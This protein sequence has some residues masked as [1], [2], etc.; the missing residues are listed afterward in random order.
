MEPGAWTVRIIVNRSASKNFY[1]SISIKPP[2]KHNIIYSSMIGF[3]QHHEI[4]NTTVMISLPA[5]AASAWTSIRASRVE[6]L[7]RIPSVWHFRVRAALCA[8][9]FAFVPALWRIEISHGNYHVCSRRTNSPYGWIT[10]CSQLFKLL[11]VLR[12]K[13]LLFLRVAFLLLFFELK[14]K[15]FLNQ[16][17]LKVN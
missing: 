1:A 12:L 4:D 3:A 14:W 10:V 2:P 16:S 11:H 9:R 13:T 17:Q 6:A 7:R 5:F 8:S 15:M